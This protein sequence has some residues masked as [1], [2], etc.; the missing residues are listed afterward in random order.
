MRVDELAENKS[1]M[2]F[3]EIKETESDYPIP[4]AFRAYTEYME[5]RLGNER[6]P[7]PSGRIG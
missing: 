6:F 7:G 5:M 4:S 1:G 2:L 3:V